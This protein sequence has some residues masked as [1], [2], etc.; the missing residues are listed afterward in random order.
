LMFHPHVTLTVEV[1]SNAASTGFS[2]EI[3]EIVSFEN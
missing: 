2:L 3:A 1:D